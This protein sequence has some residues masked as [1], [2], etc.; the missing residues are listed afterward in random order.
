MRTTSVKMLAV[1]KHSCVSKGKHHLSALNAMGA[2][3][4]YKQ[5]VSG[6]SPLVRTANV[7]TDKEISKE[8]ASEIFSRL[9]S[10]NQTCSR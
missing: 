3:L 9:S 8:K 5:E 6:S 4:P 2:C 7:A 1:S 10:R